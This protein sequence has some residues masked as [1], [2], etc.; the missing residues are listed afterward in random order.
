MDGLERELMDDFKLFLK[1][2]YQ[3][4][5]SLVWK[6]D[7]AFEQ[8][9]PTIQQHQN[10]VFGCS[11]ISITE[12]RKQKVDFSPPYM[13]DISVLITSKKIPLLSSEQDFDNIDQQLTAITIKGTTY[14]SDLLALKKERGAEFAIQHIPSSENILRT[15]SDKNN[16]FGFIDL[17]IYLM[18][19][20]R[21]NG[22]SVNRQNLF[23]K[24]RAGYSFIL[25][26][27]SDW[28]IPLTEYFNSTQFDRK[29]EIVSVKYF[30]KNIYQF[31]ESLMSNPEDDLIL[32]N[33]E[34]E[35]QQENLQGKNQQLLEQ[36]TVRK[37][38]IATILLSIIVLVSLYVLYFKS[39]RANELLKE[40][41]SKIEAQG[42]SIEHQNQQLELKANRLLHLNEEKNNLIKIVAHDLRSPINQ[43]QGLA[44][45]FLLQNK[46]LPPDQLDLIQKIIDS[47]V[48][49]NTMIAKI[50][51][52]DAIETN[53]VNLIM[54]NIQA[55][56]LLR[57]VVA[58]FEK[59]ANSKNILLQLE[60]V[61]ENCTF[62]A[63]VLFFIEIMENLIS[64]AIKFSPRNKSIMVRMEEAPHSI[65]F[66]VIDQGPGLT[67]S[68]LANLFEKYQR[69]SARPT[70]GESSTGLGL[71]IVKKYV[72]L[73]NGKVW[74]ESTSE[75]GATF[76]VQFP[77][78]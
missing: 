31:I 6:E 56:A 19:L 54:E 58:S 46:S 49:L 74:A 72:E 42:K 23:S 41:K 66:K 17:P 10:G 12:E 27:G 44:Q 75:N 15:I 13:A 14:E 64:N 55:T 50:L 34:K 40:Q 30:D 4:D 33:K 63:D 7:R 48:R 59:Q 60:A 22:F 37:F 26:K 20:K 68:D 9:F 77:K 45:I 73:M 53:R 2:R 36:D 52:V 21:D 51:D 28:Q 62:R 1:D 18:E 39:S 5:L 16:G 76:F 65:T 35:I 47:S 67:E 43:V 70:D 38:L 61:N 11:A 71:S 24:K 25:P 32:L 78:S 29:M 69:L 57:R 3:V 8:I